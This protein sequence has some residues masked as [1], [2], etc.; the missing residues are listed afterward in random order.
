MPPRWPFLDHPGPIPFAHQG[1]ASDFPENTMRAFQHAVD[2]GYR[3]IETDVHATLDGVLVAFHDDT[4]DRV[5]DRRGVIGELRWADIS[6]ARVG[7]GDDRIPRLEDLLG[8]WPDVRVNIDPKHD[9]SVTPLVE[10]LTRTAAFERVC[11]GAFSGRRLARFRR[12]TQNRVCTSMG[13]AEV[14]RLRASSYGV[15]VGRFAPA[16]ACAQVPTRAARM[17]LVDRRF[18]DAAHRGGLQVHV[19]TINDADEM[20]G[21]LDLGVDGIMTDRP[22]VLKAVLERRQA[23]A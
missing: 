5:T 16:C 13:P 12:L 10:V 14:A 6:Q 22:A 7:D 18:V 15:P 2:L 21:L 3:Y 19:W 11:I 17:P 23:W 9:A 1:G 20:D 4:L 8:T